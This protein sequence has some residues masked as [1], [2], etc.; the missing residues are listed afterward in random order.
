MARRGERGAGYL[1][2]V[3]CVF[4]ISDTKVRTVFESGGKT[5]TRALDVQNLII[6]YG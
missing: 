1:G 6:L 2:S 3:I 5:Q 4:F